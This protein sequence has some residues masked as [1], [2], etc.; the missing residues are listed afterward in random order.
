MKSNI[1]I[2]NPASGNPYVCILVGDH[3]QI[4]LKDGRLY[5]W[6]LEDNE[7]KPAY[8]SGYSEL[9]YPRDLDELLDIRDQMEE[10]YGK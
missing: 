10:L 7:Q 9:S 8:P 3:M 6:C 2:V 5:C 4:E 1:Q